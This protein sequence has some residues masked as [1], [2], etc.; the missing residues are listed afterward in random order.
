M[1][2][3]RILLTGGPG[4]GKSSALSQLR[5]M[6]LKRAFNVFVIEENA[7]R[8]IEAAGGFDPSWRER[9]NL[10]KLQKTFLTFQK[11]QEDVFTA[12][13][14]I[15]QGRT[16]ILL[17]RGILD[18]KVFVPED[19]WSEITS[20][21]AE[22]WEAEV[23][24]RYDLVLHMTSVAVDR[25]ELYEF[26]PGSNNPARFHDVHEARS[27]DA[28]C[29]EIYAKHPRVVFVRTSE[30]FGEKN[31]LVLNA[32]VE[33]CKQFFDC[34]ETNAIKLTAGA[35]EKLSITVDPEFTHNL[36]PQRKE[37]VSLVVPLGVKKEGAKSCIIATGENIPRTE[38]ITLD[39]FL[40]QSQRL[41]MFEQRY[42]EG[43]RTARKTISEREFLLELEALNETGGA[44]IKRQICWTD[45]NNHYFSLTQYSDAAGD[46]ALTDPRCW[47]LD[48]PS[49]API[50]TALGEEE[51]RAPPRRMLKAQTTIDACE[52]AEENASKR[53]KLEI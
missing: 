24:A 19:I 22:N 6:L 3:L 52:V 9:D 49:H 20:T 13:S 43:A 5:S 50:P 25:P 14:E 28:R 18:G 32:I 38:R 45:E 47:T 16:V 31:N 26:G 36:P 41:F 1:R 17:D 53:R 27:Q 35:R 30:S 44:V 23:L 15:K 21:E 46:A 7:T 42:T 34:G 10:V 48:K 12:L 39:T 4:G 40:L 11:T 8:V 37:L 29:A 51:N 33:M 2:P